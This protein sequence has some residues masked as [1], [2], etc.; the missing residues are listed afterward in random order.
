V[1]ALALLFA[2][3]GATL[4][5]VSHAHPSDIPH[6][7][8][9]WTLTPTILIPVALALAFYTCGAFRLFQRSNLG[10]A[11]LRRRAWLFAAGWFT[12]AAAA[13]S[14]LHEA[15]ESS[16]TLH[17]VEH[18]LLMLVAAPLLVLSRPLE[19]MLWS[20]P[21]AA[22]KWL[23]A[24]FHRNAMQTAWHF[25]SGAVLAT[26][27]QAAAL[28]LW[29][30][31]TLFE[32]A[33]ADDAWH[34]G[35]HLSFLISAL[36]FWSAMFHNRQA[37]GGRGLAV[38]CLFATSVISGALGALMA[39]SQSPWYPRYAVMG[40]APFGLTPVEDQQLAGL[41]MWIPGGLVHAVAALVLL[42]ALLRDSATRDA[43]GNA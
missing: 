25:L 39:F 27:L 30:A 22:R 33:L 6:A 37:A 5:V 26:V 36:L 38:L 18:E 34:I 28:W 42:G 1:L 8:P 13:I 4:P 23:G 31:P 40:L 20:W 15:G 19:T 2:I 9:G 32:R 11:E 24:S 12:L 16:F 3:A 17:M 10:R 41:L 29:H 43:Q 35:Q 21:A 14:P 7:E